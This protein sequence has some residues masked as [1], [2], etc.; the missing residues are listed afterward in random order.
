MNDRHETN[1]SDSHREAADAA[2]APDLDV[3]ITRIVDGEASL[4][5]RQ[6]FE[7]LASD[8]A[9]LW[10]RL[11]LRQQ[12]MTMLATHVEP[13]L[14]RA[15]KVDVPAAATNGP[16]LALRAGTRPNGEVDGAAPSRFSWLMA[17]SGWAALIALAM[18]WGSAALRGRGESDAASG[19][20]HQA[21]AAT[22]ILPPEAHLQQYMQAPY[23]MGDM[24]PTLLQV[25]QLSDGRFAVSYLRRIV[26]VKYY[27]SATDIPLD[28]EGNLSSS[29]RDIRS[30]GERVHP[31]P[32]PRE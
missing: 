2:E 10:R 27:D 24:P 28:D 9:S 5:L 13:M 15:E 21:D 30:A 16:V 19:N 6:R 14:N 18:A 26:E 22:S 8:D 31:R 23:V 17:A 29:P 25:D 1:P 7:A 4:A 12:D 3:M 32:A 20:L 11:A